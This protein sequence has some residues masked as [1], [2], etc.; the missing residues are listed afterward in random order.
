[1]VARTAGHVKTV[2]NQEDE[3]TVDIGNIPYDALER[4]LDMF[5][6]ADDYR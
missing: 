6:L 2:S 3:L 4:I 1:M 5:E